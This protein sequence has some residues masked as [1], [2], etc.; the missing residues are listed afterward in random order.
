MAEASRDQALEDS[1]KRVSCLQRRLDM[2]QYAMQSAQLD[3]AA[4]NEIADS[5]RQQVA[6][7]AAEV[8]RAALRADAAAAH[9][10]GLEA[11]LASADADLAEVRNMMLQQHT[12]SGAASAEASAH[13]KGLEAQVR[14]L[15]SRLQVVEKQVQD[16]DRM[17]E[18]GPRGI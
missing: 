17:L 7:L 10:S 9:A 6:T 11:A 16:R 8:H 15:T 3:A 14:G 5:A 2:Q 4:A 13:T 1:R 18:T 12:E